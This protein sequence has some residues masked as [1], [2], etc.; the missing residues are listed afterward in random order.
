MLLQNIISNAF[1]S[2]LV[3]ARFSKK[4][5]FLG[6]IIGCRKERFVALYISILIIYTDYVDYFQ[7]NVP[8][9]DRLVV[10]WLA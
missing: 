1:D 4:S 8:R 10:T 6:Y 2:K 5:V 9:E 7:K 3:Q